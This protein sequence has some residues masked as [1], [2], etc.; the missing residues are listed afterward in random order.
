MDISTA[1]AADLDDL[2]NA[3]DQPDTGLESVL[4]AFTSDARA[5]VRSFSGLTMTIFTE[6]AP[7]SFTV[8]EPRAAEEV[9]AASLVLPLPLLGPFDAGSH[10]VLYAARAGAFVDLSAD[11][12]FAVDV[13][14]FALCLD[15]H[16]EMP[17]HT[18]ASGLSDISVVNQAIGVLI[19]RGNTPDQA[20]AELHRSAGAS[21]M[22]GAARQVITS[23]GAQP[24]GFD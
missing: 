2:T 5:A 11:L 20:R 4:R 13:D 23:I 22:V 21:G 7:F 18:V 17:D 3:L 9:A 12:A 19:D 16:L 8:L 24:P 15:E 14:L 6:G 1:L 10:L